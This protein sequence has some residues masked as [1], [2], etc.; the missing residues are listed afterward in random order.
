MYRLSNDQLVALATVILITSVPI[1]WA[2]AL[3]GHY[4]GSFIVI[5]VSN[6]AMIAIAIYVSVRR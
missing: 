2:L 6:L 1:S 4:N 5:V 3:V